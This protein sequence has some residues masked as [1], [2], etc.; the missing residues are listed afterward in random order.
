MHAEHIIVDIT[1]GFKQGFQGLCFFRKSDPTTDMPENCIV[2]LVKLMFYIISLNLC[3]VWTQV[4]WFRGRDVDRKKV[5]L[6]M[7]STT[8]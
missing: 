4:T 7:Q 6:A 5:I 8:H 3:S 1:Q 2:T